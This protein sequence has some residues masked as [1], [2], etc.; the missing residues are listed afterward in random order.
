MCTAFCTKVAGGHNSHQAG[1]PRSQSDLLWMVGV[2]EARD[3]GIHG[4]C[5]GFDL[6]WQSTKDLSQFS[7]TESFVWD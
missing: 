7:F 6:D 1:N 3:E 2:F 4:R 5:F